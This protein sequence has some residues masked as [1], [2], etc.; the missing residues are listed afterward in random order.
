MPSIELVRRQSSF[1]P[2]GFHLWI[3]SSPMAGWEGNVNATPT[4][5]IK[6]N[7]P[8][9]TINFQRTISTVPRGR[10]RSLSLYLRSLS[11][12]LLRES[13][14]KRANTTTILKG[15]ENRR[16]VFFNQVAV[17]NLVQYF[18]D[19][20]PNI[21]ASGSA[22]FWFHIQCTCIGFHAG[23]HALCRASPSFVLN[24]SCFV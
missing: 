12:L 23:F 7:D 1:A 14:P 3:L 21:L 6:R 22:G 4:K 10:A 13:V 20:E 15:L 24:L 5:Q 16:N 17:V 19:V 8:R 18:F 11:H 2:A 9:P